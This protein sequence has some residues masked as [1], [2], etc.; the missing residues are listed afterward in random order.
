MEKKNH[1]ISDQWE[2]ILVVLVV[3]GGR[4]LPTGDRRRE[5]LV[6]FSVW[7]VSGPLCFGEL[8]L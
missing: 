3:G 5:T 4:G 6:L 2:F 7:Q 1:T 8:L